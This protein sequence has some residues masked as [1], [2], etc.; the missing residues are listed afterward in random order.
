[1][2]G[3]KCAW[4]NKTI[5]PFEKG[6]RPIYEKPE[7]PFVTFDISQIRLIGQSRHR[8]R[9]LLRDSKSSF[10]DSTDRLVFNVTFPCRII[11]KGG[12]TQSY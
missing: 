2:T 11:L 1:M 3:L 6:D 9:Q 10:V 5:E 4:L 8:L 7:E 12:G